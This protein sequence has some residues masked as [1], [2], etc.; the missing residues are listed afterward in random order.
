MSANSWDLG[1]VESGCLMRRHEVTK[2]LKEYL[3]MNTGSRRT[4]TR[5]LRAGDR[6][7][8]SKANG[9]DEWGETLELNISIM[10][11]DGPQRL[12]LEE[13]DR[14]WD[15]V[16]GGIVGCLDLGLEID[17]LTA[18]G[19]L[20]NGILAREL[21]REELRCDGDDFLVFGDRS[22]LGLSN[23]DRPRSLLEHEKE[24]PEKEING[25]ERRKKNLLEK[26]E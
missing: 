4:S 26:N 14:P 23:N 11:C 9:D 6:G 13:E 25:S 19:I 3:A 15:T 18:I 21:L 22:S 5:E 16:A 10:E 2:M 20:G 12:V 1:A 7:L 24:L 8:E 17:A